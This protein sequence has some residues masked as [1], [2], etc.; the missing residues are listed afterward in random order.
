MTETVALPPD[1]DARVHR[2]LKLACARNRPTRHRRVNFPE[3]DRGGVR[4]RAV[5]LSLDMLEDVLDGWGR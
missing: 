2:F 4:L 3:T 1:L 5:G